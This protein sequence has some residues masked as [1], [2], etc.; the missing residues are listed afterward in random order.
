MTQEMKNSLLSTSYFTVF[1]FGIP[2]TFV[3]YE[4]VER[5]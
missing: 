3:R 5:K 4:V 2:V 1:I